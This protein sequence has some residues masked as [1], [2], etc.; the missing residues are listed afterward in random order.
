MSIQKPLD[1]KNLVPIDPNELEFDL[2]FHIHSLIRDEHFFAKI[3]RYIKKVPTN[4]I[5]TAG[6]ALNPH[7]ISYELL[8]NPKFFLA[9][10]KKQRLWVLMH[11]FYHI[12]LG[13]ITTRRPESVPMQKANIA[14]DEAINS[15]PN[16]INEAP[17]FVIVPGKTPPADTPPGAIGWLVK[18]HQPG[19]AMEYYLNLLPD[20]T[21]G[22]DSFDV[23]EFWEITDENG[24]PIEDGDAIKEIA[25]HKLREIIQKAADESDKESIEGSNGWG[26]VSHE[27]RKRI[28]ESLLVKLDPKKV[29][30][31]FIKTSV[32]ADKKHRIT[33][34]NRRW[35]YIHPGR[36]YDRRA[37]VAISIDQS[38]S[39]S[40][41]M[42]EK[43]FGWLNEFSKYAEFVVIP[44]DDRVFEEKVY[45]WKKGQKRIA[46]RV[47]M[48]G[49]NFS[50]PS[51]YVN[52]RDFDGHIICTDMLA[53]RPIPSKVQRMWITDKQHAQNPYF[54]THE[55]IL[56]I[57]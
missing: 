11:E 48:G 54:K 27:M 24:N 12:A 43:F 29:L 37:R 41:E 20:D 25:A 51:A 49:T 39:V 18:D 42:L 19:Q 17:S 22:G 50:A 4:S 3:S 45:V 8:Y 26:S 2:G 16:M 10:E 52:E 30:Q 31:Y 55:R 53:E 1:F 28:R 34:I 7:T 38:G 35:P 47:L 6:V 44:F 14:M 13:H 36:S 23:H 32:R 56:A 9:L 40:D 33:K 21:G 5:P 15:L 57:D 46:E